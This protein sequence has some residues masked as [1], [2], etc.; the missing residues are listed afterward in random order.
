MPATDVMEREV[1]IL[2]A[3]ACVEPSKDNEPV[4]GLAGNP[5][6]CGTVP[7]QARRLTGTF[8]EG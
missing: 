5:C 6:M 4:K 3:V 2:A 7:G 8:E 1:P